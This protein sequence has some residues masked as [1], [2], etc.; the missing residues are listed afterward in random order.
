MDNIYHQYWQQE[1][2]YQLASADRYRKE[3]M[4][5]PLFGRTPA[6][7]AKRTCARQERICSTQTRK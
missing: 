4:Y 6:S 7:S 1:L 2:M 5:A 3:P